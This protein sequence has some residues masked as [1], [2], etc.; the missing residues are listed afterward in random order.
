[1]IKHL[2]EKELESQRI[3]WNDM[4]RLCLY[5]TSARRKKW[6]EF[7]KKKTSPIW[8]VD[9]A[10]DYKRNDDYVVICADVGGVCIHLYFD[11]HQISGIKK[12]KRYEYE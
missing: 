5:N 8:Y 6:W 9:G 3:L 2:F 12:L 1:M 11:F 10:L 4:V 7:W